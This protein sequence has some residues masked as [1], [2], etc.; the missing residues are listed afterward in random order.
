M[1]K[2]PIHQADLTILNVHR[3]KN[4]PSKYLIKNGK[5]KGKVDKFTMEISTFLHQ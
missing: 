1:M 3:T 5:P 4:R 2:G